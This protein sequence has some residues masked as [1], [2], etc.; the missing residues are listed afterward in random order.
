MHRKPHCDKGNAD[1]YPVE[2]FKKFSDKLSPLLLDM[3]SDSLSQ[4]VLPRTLTEAK[5]HETIIAFTTLL[6]RRRILLH[7]KSKIPP[8]AS[9]WLRNLMQYIGKAKI[10]T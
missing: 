1:G 10:C 5:K 3:F 4:G 8:K 6:A 7:W 9:L 2:F